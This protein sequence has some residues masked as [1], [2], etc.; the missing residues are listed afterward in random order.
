MPYIE[1]TPELH[2]RPVSEADHPMLEAW[3]EADPEHRGRSTVEFFSR[4]S[5]NCYVLMDTQGP[6]FFLKLT[7]AIRMDVQFAPGV[8]MRERTRHGLH[9]GF[10]V[11]GELLAEK[12]FEEAIFE[13]KNTL[14]MRSME[15][16]TGFRRSPGEMVCA[17]GSARGKESGYVRQQ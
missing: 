6:V 14:L 9:R 1:L 17:L 3:I 16:R 2:L 13:S 12:G 4:P 5:D 11:L 7:R 15:K 8:E 10:E